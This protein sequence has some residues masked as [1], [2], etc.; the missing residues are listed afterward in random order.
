MGWSGGSELMS[1]IIK[2][3][4]P[5]IPDDKRKRFYVGVIRAFQGEDAD[6]LGECIGQDE[7]FDKAFYYLNPDAEPESED[8]P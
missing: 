7:K 5:A 2:Y 4:K 1:E 8:G 6:T 3:A